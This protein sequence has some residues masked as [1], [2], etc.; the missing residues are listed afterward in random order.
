M[1]TTG[2]KGS[3]VNQ[4]QVSCALGQ[5]ALEGRRVPRM[6]S[7]RTMPSFSPYDPN[8]RADGFIADRFLTGVRPQEYYF[9][10]MAGREGLVDTAV[11]TS[12]SG[13][14]QR[15]L[16]K[17]LE[18]LK[19]SYDHTVRDG[20]GGIVQFLYGEDGIDPT[21]SAYLSGSPSTL[22]YIA[23]NHRALKHNTTVLPNNTLEIANADCGRNKMLNKST[24]ALLVKGSFVKAR[25]LRFGSEW[26]RGT[27]CR[28]WFSALVTKAYPDGLHFDIHFVKDGSQAIHV[29]LEVQFSYAGGKTT[30]AAS[31]ICTI[32]KPSVP[33]PILSDCAPERGNHRI[34]SSGACVSEK[35]AHSTVDV[36]ANNAKLKSVM[37]TIGLTA[38]ELKSV[39][40]AK[41]GSAL[42]APGEA[43][44]CIAGQSIGEP[45]TQMTLNTFHLAGSGANVTLGI[46]RL[47]EIIMTASK[48]L[49]TPTMSVPLHP[50]VTETESTRLTHF[51]TEL[52]LME[53]IASHDGITVIESIQQGSAGT[54]E[55]AYQIKLKLHSLERIREAFELTVEEIALIVS[56]KFLPNIIRIMKIE[57]KRSNSDSDFTVSVKGGDA[58]DFVSDQKVTKSSKKT[59]GESNEGSDDEDDIEE[60]NDAVGDEDGVVA[61]R[62]GPKKEMSSYGDMDEEDKEC[63]SL[64]N[65]SDQNLL[66][67]NNAQE[68]IV[69]EDDENVDNSKIDSI[70]FSEKV[71]IDE[72]ENTLVLQPLQVDPSARPLLMIDL[73]E[74]AAART[75]VRSRPGINQA[76]INEEEGRDRCLQTAGC[77]FT[78]LWNLVEVDHSL[79][80][81]NDIW[82]VCCS[83]GVEAARMT[84]VEQ[85][86]SVFA[87]YGISVDPRHLTLIADYMTY[88]GGFKAMSRLGMAEASSSFL[89]MTFETTAN[90]M[91]DAALNNRYEPMMSPSANI[92]VGRPIRH[93]TGAFD[94][95]VK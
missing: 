64:E 50:S 40:A 10:C 11:K 79:I 85:I 21:K 59:K 66:L 7:G 4:S 12:R 58:V 34:G 15:C 17:H 77:N 32:I 46:P 65:K 94:C 13:Y 1:V 16:V 80:S 22:E 86:R 92:V 90:F 52:A 41:F 68:A 72:D 6:S 45:S 24:T 91:I 30:A 8:P 93:G 74:R 54:W 36:I 83:Y 69:K 23:R 67:D 9:H 51:F 20:E 43:V 27:L 25:K 63:L 81:S 76:F 55:R 29:P 56:S 62:F 82:A 14:L 3:T 39:V 37:K 70:L 71:H 26:R 38:E 18:E 89:Q 88:N 2:A 48:Q 42:C 57:L 35:I 49:K 28:G 31:R 61:S 33:D 5:Q 75:L 78:E 87:V 84:I 95:I 47:R 73:V 60:D 19:V 44:G 53:L